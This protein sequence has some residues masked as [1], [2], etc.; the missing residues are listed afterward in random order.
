MPPVVLWTLPVRGINRT[1]ASGQGEFAVFGSKTCLSD[2]KA[3]KQWDS[4]RAAGRAHREHA[5]QS[6]RGIR[7]CRRERVQFCRLGSPLW[8]YAGDGSQVIY[9][10]ARAVA[11]Q[12][13]HLDLVW[14]IEAIAHDR[15]TD[16]A[17]VRPG[18]TSVSRDDRALAGHICSPLTAT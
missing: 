3:E 11:V 8:I 12:P 10:L 6:S 5:R 4:W 15:D 7:I 14:N 9:G 13:F 17:D 2:W 16:P 1:A 18:I